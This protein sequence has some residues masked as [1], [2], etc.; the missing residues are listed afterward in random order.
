MH[1][2]EQIDLRR[3]PVVL[4]DDAEIAV[5]ADALLREFVNLGDGAIR[6]RE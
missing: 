1:D 2:L 5:I 4:P 3:E 6:V